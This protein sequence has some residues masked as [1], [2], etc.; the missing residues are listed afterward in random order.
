MRSQSVL[1]PALLTALIA[2]AIGAFA[3]TGCG[4]DDETSTEADSTATSVT[5][6]D[7]GTS[8]GGSDASGESPSFDTVLAC[9]QGEGLD[10]QDQSSDISGETIGIDYSSGRTVISFEESAEDAETAASVAESY[11]EVLTSGTIVASLDTSP[12][13]TAD[14]DKI[15]SCI[16]P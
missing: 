7:S 10:A 15:E 13:A 11:G 16:S 9:L 12:E 8:S 14:A 2:L 1:R 6:S 5:G 3:A 4:G